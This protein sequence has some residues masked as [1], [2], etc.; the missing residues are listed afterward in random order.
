M[1]RRETLSLAKNQKTYILKNFPLDSGQPFTPSSAAVTVLRLW[2]S[3]F[4]IFSTK[5]SQSAA[6]AGLIDPGSASN[7]MSWDNGHAGGC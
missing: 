4:F 2:C 7:Q 6:E 1:W 3:D 5:L